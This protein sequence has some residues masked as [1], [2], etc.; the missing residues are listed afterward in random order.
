MCHSPTLWTYTTFLLL[1][2]F[3]NCPLKSSLYN[4]STCS[5]IHLFLHAVSWGSSLPNILSPVFVFICVIGT[6]ASFIY[7]VSITVNRSNF[8]QCLTLFF[9]SEICVWLVRILYP[10][11]Y[12]PSYRYRGNWI[13]V[14]WEL[15][16]F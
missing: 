14:I 16:E 2:L 8:F 5:F 4:F 10:I 15:S 6:F 12:P 9:L 13:I 1:L 7:A 11:V 3:K